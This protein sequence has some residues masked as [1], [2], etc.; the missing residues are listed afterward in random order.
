MTRAK[1]IKHFIAKAEKVRIIN[2]PSKSKKRNKI[3]QENKKIAKISTRN[4]KIAKL[5]KILSKEDIKIVPDEE[6]LAIRTVKKKAKLKVKRKR[7]NITNYIR[8]KL[9]KQAE[10]RIEPTFNTPEKRIRLT[11]V[12]ELNQEVV[13]VMDRFEV[14]INIIFN[15]FHKLTYIL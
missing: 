5:S 7:N 1:S 14:S 15:R 3:Y 6:I 13:S 12:Y 4:I 2:L 11:D 10:L 8:R 9:K